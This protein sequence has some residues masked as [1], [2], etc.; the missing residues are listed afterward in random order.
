MAAEGIDGALD[1][2]QALAGNPDMVTRTHFAR[3]MVATGVCRDTHEVFRRYM[4]R[5]KPGYVSQQWATLHDAVSWICGAG[6]IAVVAHPA[7]YKISATEEWA[8]FDQFKAHGGRGVEVQT[9][10]HSEADVARYGALAQQHGLLASRGSDFHS[11]GE[12]RI[13]LG[14]LPALPTG[15]TPVWSELHSRIARGA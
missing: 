3:W 5:G 11:P 12:S 8:L 9:A 1:G 7:R 2:A 4:V 6:G 14:A 13:E 10:S 15:L